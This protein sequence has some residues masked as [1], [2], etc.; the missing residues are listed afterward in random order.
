MP[1]W[2]LWW[3]YYQINYSASGFLIF[4]HFI[5]KSIQNDKNLKIRQTLHTKSGNGT[6][7]LTNLRNLYLVQ[8]AVW[9]M[10]LYMYFCILVFL[11]DFTNKW[12][13]N[14]QPALTS[15]SYVM[16]CLICVS[17]NTSIDKLI[18]CYFCCYG[19]PNRLLCMHQRTRSTKHIWRWMF[20]NI[21][22]LNMRSTLVSSIHC[23]NKVRLC[24]KRDRFPNWFQNVYDFM[25]SSVLSYVC[26]E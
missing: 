9:S 1:H 22:Y 13:Q 7:I 3:K 2:L 16:S 17:F 15:K 6:F 8:E 20:S 14:F 21:L 12:T 19:Y 26:I 18:M 10:F 4:Y 23:P 11:H 24:V 5:T 25:T